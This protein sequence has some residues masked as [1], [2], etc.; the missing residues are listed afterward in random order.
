MGFTGV[1]RTIYLLNHYN[2][3]DSRAA[4]QGFS[5]SIR[6]GNTWGRPE[7]IKIPYF[8]NRSENHGAFIS[9]DGQVLIFS[10][11]GYSTVG[12]EDIYVSFNEGNGQWSEPLNLGRQI[13]TSAQEFTP[14]LSGDKRTLYFSSNGHKGLGSSDVFMSQRLDDSWKNW[15][16]PVP[17]GQLNSQGRELAYRPYDGFALYTSTVNSDGYS[18]IRMYTD[19]P[20]QQI[21]P[22]IVDVPDSV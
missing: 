8:V 12:G 14:V 2:R 20:D 10:I 7:N 6:R 11:E 3:D 4:T 21:E 13:N 19:R 5:R 16:A 17:V 1:A 15:S 9:K 22:V 18:D